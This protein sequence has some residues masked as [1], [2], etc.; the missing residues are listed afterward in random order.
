MRAW[1]I[2]VFI[3]TWICYAGLYFC[4][5]A[6]YVAKPELTLKRGLDAAALGWLGVVYLVAYACGE[7]NAA[8]VGS[9][10]GARRTLLAGMALSVVAN[11][12][13]GLA[14]G[15]VLF[16]VL[17]AL[18]G[19]G[20]AT[21]W[22]GNVGTMAQWF[23]RTERGQVMGLWSTC[24]QLGAV[25][26]KS[27]AGFN[28]GKQGRLRR[29]FWGASGVLSTVWVAFFVLHRNRP[30]DVGL[31]PL[32]EEEPQ[33]A[34]AGRPPAREGGWSPDLIA[35]VAMMG[36]FY[37]FVKSI[38]YALW[39]WAP[40]FLQLN[41]KV[42]ADQAGYYSAIFDV[43]G[44]V[45]V[46]VAGTLSDRMFKG[47]RAGVA[48]VMIVGLCASTALLWLLGAHSLTGFGVCIGLIG[49]NLYGPDALI[50]GA[51]AIDVGSRRHALAAA[52]IINGMG[53]VGPVLQE[54]VIGNL[55]KRDPTNLSQILGLLTGAAVAA[56]VMMGL[57]LRRARA[58][59]CNL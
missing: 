41:F 18:N 59:K 36:C 43:C 5:H 53:S 31:Q 46:V 29:A 10:I 20:Q 50:T 13:F 9:R 14:E 44:F 27:F 30:E 38:R 1:R 35:T 23:R 33:P 19:I 42:P 54:V 12:G 6:Y 55:Y 15:S 52:G 2:R 11:L 32:D 17:L 8:A 16:G 3:A 37:F 28:L 57:L 4:R 26:A 25:A 51:G 49:F 22:S 21:G 39:S 48:F 24:Y 47:R 40:Y 58:G 34:V 56:T 45:G 7:F